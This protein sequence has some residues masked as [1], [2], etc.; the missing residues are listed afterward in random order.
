MMAE[1]PSGKPD[2][3]THGPPH[4]FV[5]VV[6]DTE[7]GYVDTWVEK[8]VD[9]NAFAKKAKRD[10]RKSFANEQTVESGASLIPILVSAVVDI[11]TIGAIS[12]HRPA[13]RRHLSDRALDAAISKLQSIRRD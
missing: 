5:H 2:P 13:I 12:P 9:T 7:P 4:G 10:N 1:L 3:A 6:L 8:N 11:L